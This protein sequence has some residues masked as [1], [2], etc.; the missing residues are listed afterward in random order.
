MKTR[1]RRR[2]FRSFAVVL[3]TA[4]AALAAAAQALAAPSSA[5]SGRCQR[6]FTSFDSSSST[7]PA[8]YNYPPPPTL[9]V[10]SSPTGEA[11]DMSVFADASSQTLRA[12]AF[13]GI[14]GSHGDNDCTVDTSISDTA[15]VQPGGGYNAGD[16]VHLVLTP[17]LHGTFEAGPSPLAPTSL[18]SVGANASLTLAD[19]ACSFGCVLA[20]FTASLD[21]A[22]DAS[23]PDAF[24][25]NGA[26]TK[27]TSW[28]WRLSSDAADDVKDSSTDETEICSVWPCTIASTDPSFNPFGA[29]IDTG[30]NSIEFAVQVGHPFTIDA[31]LNVLLQAYGG[32]G[33]A[34][35]DLAHTFQFSLTPAAG[36]EGVTVSYESAGSSPDT[37]PP[38]ID[39][40]AADG[41]WHGA[42]VSLGCT[43]HDDGSGLAN[44]DDASFSLSTSVAAGSETADAA[45]DTRQVCDTAGNCAT[46]GPI[47]GNHVD[48][49]A[50]TLHL[51]ASLSV[52]ATSPAGSVVTY[53]ATAT[54]GTDSSPTVTCRPASG[55]T[56]AIGSTT[57]D[58]TATDHAGNTTSGAFAVTVEGAKDQ[59]NDLIQKVVAST[60][61]PATIKTQLVGSL[62]TLV[63]RF[64]PTNATQR[65][66]VCG[67]LK[68]FATGVQILSG[69]A[70]PTAVASEW[71]ADANR[72]RA[73][74]ACS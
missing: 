53:V 59:L 50:P 13:L 37:S 64:D 12:L 14:D 56:F 45:T 46:A 69:R 21:E 26:L 41:L 10:P 2:P 29:A 47:G 35:A 62:Q 31:R 63:A 15:T 54:D 67:A 60:S 48:R 22:T 72:I 1:S 18:T 42:N 4:V 74:L 55:A 9:L 17:G 73:V 27:D 30:T 51:P 71:I 20:E 40:A 33:L 57:V 19:A 6:N 11:A 23:A 44:A 43:A 28:R 52:D 34:S 3:F 58:C 25:P 66:L 24:H 49:A 65:Q 70:L 39:C 68:L 36:Y 5:I 7:A 16:I 32:L 8:R 38:V 61:L